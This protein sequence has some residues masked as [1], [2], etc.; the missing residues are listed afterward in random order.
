[1][2]RV[3][4]YVTMATILHIVDPHMCT[5]YTVS[6]KPHEDDTIELWPTH[7][8]MDIM[9]CVPVGVPDTHSHCTVYTLALCSHNDQTSD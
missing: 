1:M 9:V 5:C 7:K 3:Q 8:G 6:Y 4:L 2:Y